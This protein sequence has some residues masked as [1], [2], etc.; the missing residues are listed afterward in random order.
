LKASGVP[1]TSLYTAFF[2]ENFTSDLLPMVKKVGDEQYQLQLPIMPDCT[3]LFDSSTALTFVLDKIF[4]YAAGETGAWVLA[5]LKD[6]KTWIGKDM[7]IVTEWLSARDMATIVG[8]VSGKKVE[9]LELDEA[10]FEGT[11]NAQ[12]PGAEEFYYNMKFFMTV[13]L[14][15]IYVD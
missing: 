4:V 7:R 12:Y 2:Y 14:L 5:A 11:K 3:L 10:A 15:S 13:K 6:P 8:R 9:P 1:R